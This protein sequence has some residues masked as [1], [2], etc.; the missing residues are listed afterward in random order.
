MPT[1]SVELLGTPSPHIVQVPSDGIR[2]GRSADCDLVV[3]SASVSAHHAYVYWLGDQLIV[4][5]LDSSFG[6]RRDGHRLVQATVLFNGDELVLGGAAMLRIAIQDGAVGVASGRLDETGTNGMVAASLDDATEPLALNLLP[7]VETL[8]QPTTIEALAATV[9]SLVLENFQSSRVALLEFDETSDRVRILGLA[10]DPAA[11]IS[12]SDDLQF[13]SRTVM[14]QATKQGV[15]LFRADQAAPQAKSLM[16]AGAHSA[17]AAR[18]LTAENHSV[19]IYLD[20]LLMRPPLTAGH[21][22]TLQLLCRNIAAAYRS[23][24]AQQEQA[25]NHARFQRLRRYFSPAVVEHIL[26]ENEHIVEQP[27]ICEATVV[28][29]DLVGYTKLSEQLKN[30][31]QRLFSVLNQW[32]DAGAQAAIAHGG[33]LDK[34]IGDCVMIVF[35]AP[36]ALAD[37]EVA[38]LNC[39]RQMLAAIDRISTE[40]GMDLQITVGINSGPVLAGSIGSRRRL[41]YTV[42]GDTVN[43]AARLQGL[44]QPN[45]ILVGSSIAEHLAAAT[46]FS[47]PMQFHL[48]NDRKLTA[49]ALAE[50]TS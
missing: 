9:V 49:Y 31:P 39:S 4:E 48:H 19:L 41:E 3:K 24:R 14:R 17:I 11:G 8:F 23:L 22:I 16:A 37:R 15:A 20:T 25:R 45:Q 1:A 26:A 36:Y 21:A 2:I 47:P 43:I 7:L 6:T 33:T 38:A 42:L 29:A 13:V 44:A 30:D 34:F 32:L 35:G 12:A 40:L 28:F 46:S 50:P 10:A 18:I 5:D 27:H